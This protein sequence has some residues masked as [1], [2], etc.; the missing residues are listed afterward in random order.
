MSSWI[1]VEWWL[2]FGY[3][4]NENLVA[5]KVTGNVM[6]NV[7]KFVEYFFKNRA[8][9]GSTVVVPMSEFK[10]TNDLSD[11]AKNW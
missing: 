10:F 1:L 7:G 5:Q 8:I 3:W 11:W 4:L 2:D 9:S 6:L